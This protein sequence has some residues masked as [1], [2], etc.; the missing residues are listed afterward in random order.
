MMNIADLA[1]VGM[2]TEL[3]EKT[4]MQILN[5]VGRLHRALHSRSITRGE[6]R[7]ML[8]EL[9][10]Q[11]GEIARRIHDPKYRF[12]SEATRSGGRPR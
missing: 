4:V 5:R 1:D 10:I 3:H 11:E 9:S 8:K 12:E 2:D 7:E 6:Q